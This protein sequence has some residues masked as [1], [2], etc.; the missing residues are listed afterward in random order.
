M[1]LYVKEHCN[2]EE[3]E[4]IIRCQKHDDE[5]ENIIAGIQNASKLMIGEQDNGDSCQVPVIKVMYFEAVEG[6]VY[7]YLEQSVIKVRNTLYELEDL[8]SNYYF[9]RI[10]KST[11][12]NLRTIKNIK[13]EEGRR[14]M[15]E[16]KNKENLVVSKNYVST[17]KKALGMKEVRK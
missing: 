9:I 13:P 2:V 4:V 16:L 12:V 7:A 11:I 5:V 1:K 8:Y 3:T 15:I 10:S 14:L 17:L 6:N